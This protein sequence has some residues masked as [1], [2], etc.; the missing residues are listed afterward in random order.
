MSI[1]RS[2][3]EAVRSLDPPGR[4]LEKDPVT[5]L[6]SDIGQRRAIEKCSQALRDGAKDLKRQLSADMGDPDFLNAVFDMDLSEKTD[7]KTEE[8]KGKKTDGKENNEKSS[9]GKRKDTKTA[10]AKVRASDKKT[11]KV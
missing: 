6:W 3:V 2:I 1:S 10:K 5:G 4:F 8:K 11:P 9:A 7:K